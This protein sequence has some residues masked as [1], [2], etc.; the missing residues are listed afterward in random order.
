MAEPAIAA[1]GTVPPVSPM[2]I[3]PFVVCGVRRETRD[4]FTLELESA[5]GGPAPRF[6]PG[7]FNMLYAFGVGEIPISISGDPT[8]RGPLTHTVRTVGVVTRA[9]ERLEP[10]GV[11]GVRGPYG[12]GW[13]V[14]DAAGADVVVVAGGIGLAPLRPV[15]LSVLAERERY[16]R[17]AL[18]YGA[19]SP[20]DIL[21]R[22]ELRRWRSA[23]HMD[24]EVTVDRGD[25]TWRGD[26]G[27]VTRLVP[28]APFDPARTVAMI[29]G[30]E[31]M[32]RFAAQELVRR[33]VARDAIWVST[34]RNMKCGVGLCG[35]CQHG[36][37]FV[38]KDGPVFR[39]DRV[40]TLLSKR[41]I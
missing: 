15:V 33:G 41:E 22:A 11:L 1:R 10:G 29:C 34:E 36:P 12:E 38:C 19:R 13:P 26:V 35:H 30:P 3:R 18:L 32:M 6:L 17:V 4:T 9:M 37:L 39:Y 2:A 27:V 16:G 24:V 20:K 25:R 31:I 28:R 7:Q 8:R 5:E 21:F 14:E 40:E 23:F